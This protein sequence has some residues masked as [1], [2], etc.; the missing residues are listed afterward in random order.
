MKDFD[1]LTPDE[2]TAYRAE[3]EKVFDPLVERQILKKVQYKGRNV[4]K[5]PINPM[6]LMA[7]VQ[8]AVEEKG[9]TPNSILVNGQLVLFSM[10]VFLSMFMSINEDGAEAEKKLDEF[11][12]RR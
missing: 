10:T 8:K 12:Q 2:Q 9:Q 4:Y 6:K 11:I 7:V 3:M 5:T 1:Q